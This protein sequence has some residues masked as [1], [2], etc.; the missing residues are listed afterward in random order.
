MLRFCQCARHLASEFAL[1]TDDNG[2]IAKSLKD[3]AQRSYM[4]FKALLISAACYGRM[5][6]S[7]MVPNGCSY[8]ALL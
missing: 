7:I 8:A 4:L 2:P 6:P 3:N 5:T 1:D